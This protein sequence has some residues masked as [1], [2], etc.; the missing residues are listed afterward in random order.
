[1]VDGLSGCIDGSLCRGIDLDWH[2]FRPH[3][4]KIIKGYTSGHDA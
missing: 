1:M 4:T 2:A 3:P